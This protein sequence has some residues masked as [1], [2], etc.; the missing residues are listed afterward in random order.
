VIFVDT[1]VLAAIYLPER[2]SD[3]A[4]RLLAG[5]SIRAISEL[6]EI[7]MYSVVSR[8]VRMREIRASDANAVIKRFE[9][10]L[11][12]NLYRRLSV[13]E[14]D[15]R[16]A[17]NLLSRF[18]SPLRTLDALHISVVMGN[19][20]RLITSDRKLAGA[21]RKLKIDYQLLRA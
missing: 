6:I 1:S 10:D 5:D 2:L 13:G 18:D 19:N 9:D 3:E 4:E 15:F 20:L 8:R 12:E 21:A 14:S 7:E 16:T 11:R 17:R